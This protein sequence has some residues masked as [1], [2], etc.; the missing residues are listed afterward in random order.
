[1]F[2]YLDING[3]E[4]T[5]DTFVEECESKCLP[6]PSITDNPEDKAAFSHYESNKLMKA[7]DDGD[8][9]EFFKVVGLHCSVF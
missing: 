8:L 9:D 1:M 2:Q 6:C 7:F 5:L 4:K 3:L